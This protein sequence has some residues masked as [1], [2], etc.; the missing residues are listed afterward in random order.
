MKKKVLAV[1]M[2]GVI[3]MGLLAEMVHPKRKRAIQEMV[4]KK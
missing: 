3:G 1:L 2:T 4:M